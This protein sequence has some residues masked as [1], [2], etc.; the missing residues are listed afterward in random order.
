MMRQGSDQTCTGG[1]NG[2]DASTPLIVSTP[3]QSATTD[4]ATTE[5]TTG[6]SLY[7]F[8]GTALMTGAGCAVY[9]SPLFDINLKDAFASSDWYTMTTV[10]GVVQSCMLVPGTSR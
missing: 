5:W 2:T 1:S 3:T 4:A 8:G 6:F 10:L 7:L 9:V